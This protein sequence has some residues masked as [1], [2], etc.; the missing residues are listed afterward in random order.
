MVETITRLIRPPS[1]VFRY[2]DVHGITW[3]RVKDA[4]RFEEV[5][6]EI[7][8]ALRRH[9]PKVLVAHNAPF[10]EGIIRASL[11]R[12]Y[13]KREDDYDLSPLPPF[14]CT[15][16]LARS[17]WR[18]SPA[19][20]AAVS[21]AMSIPL[22]HH[23]AESDARA[24]ARVFLAALRDGVGPKRYPPRKCLHCAKKA[25]RLIEYGQCCDDCADRL[26]GQALRALADAASGKRSRG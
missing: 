14:R 2:S 16:D 7:D 19:N 25:R 1:K 22:T 12:F 11:L 17:H 6:G 8:A 4:P 13:K 5:W 24:A 9:A 20:L 10:D 3:E 18:M 15:L 21:N 26:R 23:D